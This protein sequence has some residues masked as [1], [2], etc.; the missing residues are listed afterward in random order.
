MDAGWLFPTLLI[1][2]GFPSLVSGFNGNW[3]EASVLDT[4]S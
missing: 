2:F 3:K 1:Q 4:A